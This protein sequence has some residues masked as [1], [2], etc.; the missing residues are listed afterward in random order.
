MEDAGTLMVVA[1]GNDGRDNDLIPDYPSN[2]PNSNV[3]SVTASTAEGESAEWARFGQTNVDIAAPGEGVYVT[4]DPDTADQYG[5]D[6]NGGSSAVG[7]LYGYVDG[8]SFSAPAAAGVAASIKA[9]KS[10][11]DHKELKA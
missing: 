9:Y 2:F 5:V 3:I 10:P 7:D 6:E 4:L 8:S 1:S 11:P